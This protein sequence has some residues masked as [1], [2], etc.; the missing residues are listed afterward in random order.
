MSFARLLERT[1]GG[2]GELA[3]FGAGPIGR[4]EGSGQRGGPK[5]QA[6]PVRDEQDARGEGRRRVEVLPGS[7]VV[8]GAE[9]AQIERLEVAVGIEQRP[10]TALVIPAPSDQRAS[11]HRGERSIDPSSLIDGRLWSRSGRHP[12][13]SVNLAKPGP[14][15]RPVERGSRFSGGV[16]HD[17]GPLAIPLR[18]HGTVDARLALIE[19]RL[20]VGGNAVE[21]VS[22]LALRRDQP[23]GGETVE[24]G[25]D[26]AFV[27]A[28]RLHDLGELAYP[29]ACIPGTQGVAE[30][31]GEYDSGAGLE[32]FVVEESTK[33]AGHHV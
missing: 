3:S 22:P 15:E 8:E 17:D 6:S 20:G 18:V 4:N 5:S 27:D 12:D 25:P 2:S 10:T 21:A 1:V 31:G 16:G 11:T 28:E 19:G 7:T 24:G 13:R 29:C 26:G 30:H 9:V 33:W 23:I 32:V 14:R